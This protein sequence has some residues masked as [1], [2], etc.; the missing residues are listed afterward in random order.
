[1]LKQI[2]M[3][4][5][6]ER[7]SIVL[8]NQGQ[9]I[10]SIL[11]KPNVPGPVPAVLFCHGFGGNKS[12]KY[13]VY[14]N[15]AEKLVAEGIAVLRIDFRGS[16]DSE[17]HFLEMT[18]NGEVSDALKGL[19]YL[20]HLNF[21]DSNRIGIFGRSL[22]GAVALITAARFSNVKSLVTWAPIFNGDQW[23]H[24]WKKVN[25]HGTSSTE[26]RELM[27]VN[28]QLASYDFFNELFNLKMEDH[29][30]KLIQVP[31]LLIHGKQDDVVLSEH[32]D[33][34]EQHRRNATAESKMIWLPHSDHDFSHPDEQERAMN[35]T[36][37]WFTRT[38]K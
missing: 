31:L 21:I 29:L 27:R 23:Q 4:N 13:R 10:F 17:G 11:H 37:Q 12:G 7:T 28:G 9:K 24:K 35:E 33:L 30:Q 34:Y 1:M 19:E 14:V 16:G 22:G 25:G 18:L 5:L 3:S 32:A 2:M 15:L 6:E 38:L 26:K 36:V 8:E 20:K